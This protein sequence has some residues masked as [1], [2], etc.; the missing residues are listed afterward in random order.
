MS[1]NLDIAVERLCERIEATPEERQRR[2]LRLQLIRLIVFRRNVQ[3]SAP[4]LGQPKA[5][6]PRRTPKATDPAAWRCADCHRTDRQSIKNPA[7]CADCARW[8]PIGGTP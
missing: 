6:S 1:T 4:L 8:Q 7:Y 2:T 3:P 5:R